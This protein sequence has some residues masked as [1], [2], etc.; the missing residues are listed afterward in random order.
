MFDAALMQI[1]PSNLESLVD[2]I[3]WPTSWADAPPGTSVFLLLTGS[4]FMTGSGR[5][6]LATA[7][8]TIPRLRA[9]QGTELY[10][11]LMSSAPWDLSHD[12]I[13][14]D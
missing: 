1:D 8:T 3:A 10:K 9:N 7:S 11:L 2:D 6:P 13:S 14:A 5:R 12:T 4:C